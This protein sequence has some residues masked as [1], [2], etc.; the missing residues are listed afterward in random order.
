[1]FNN[2]TE[3]ISERMDYLFQI[4]KKDR[5]DGTERLERLRQIPPETGKFI[6]LLFA[7][8]PP[9]VAVEIG[10]SAGYSTLWLSLAFSC[11]D[12]KVEKAVK[13]RKEG[14]Q[15]L[16]IHEGDFWKIV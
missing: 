10:T 5:M 1:M 8:S 16:I 14:H 6:S 3:E 12:R 13:M 11:Y 15:I 4:D 2:I 7:S 9:G